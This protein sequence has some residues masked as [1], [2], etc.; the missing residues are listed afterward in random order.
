MTKKQ[1]VIRFMALCVLSLLTGCISPTFSS[2]H[3]EVVDASNRQVYQVSDGKLLLKPLLR[4]CY[5]A[6]GI[7]KFGCVL[8][9]NRAVSLADPQELLRAQKLGISSGL[10]E[11][12][13]KEYLPK[14]PEFRSLERR[15][16]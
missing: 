14:P 13:G 16:D 4:D 6:L 1:Y 2:H 11:P 10:V 15:N 9:N 8:E 12:S 3:Q 7:Y 5:D